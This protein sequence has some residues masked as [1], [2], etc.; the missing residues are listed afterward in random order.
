MAHEACQAQKIDVPVLVI[1]GEHDQVEPAGV[2][3]RNL[4]P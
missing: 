1:A 4:V 2:L 3:R